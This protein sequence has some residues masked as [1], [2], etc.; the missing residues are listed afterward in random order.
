MVL[1]LKTQV[2]T[3]EL[4][5]KV[6]VLKGEA[7][8]LKGVKL[9]FELLIIPVFRIRIQLNS[10]PDPSYFKGLSKALL[11]PGVILASF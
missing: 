8:E 1:A 4:R 5:G 7:P 2:Y 9:Y 3:I 6:T 10:D 11:W